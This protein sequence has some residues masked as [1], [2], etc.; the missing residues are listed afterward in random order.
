MNR[1]REELN[2]LYYSPSQPISVYIYKYANTHFLATGI[3]AGNENYPS[4]IQ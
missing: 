2:T 1:A 3:H 4:A